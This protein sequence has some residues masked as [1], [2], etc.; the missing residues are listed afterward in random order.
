MRPDLLKE[1]GIDQKLNQQVPLDFTFRDETGK[2]VQLGQYFGRKPVILSLVYYNCPMLCTQVLNG[3]GSEHG[4][5]CRWTSATEFN[6][7]TVSIDPSEE[8]V[9]AT[10]KQNVHGD[11]RPAR[12]RRGLAFPDRR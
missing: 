10:V 12:R 11:V 6:V 4:R 3:H 8:P 2:T 9:L 7:V 1:V 5:V